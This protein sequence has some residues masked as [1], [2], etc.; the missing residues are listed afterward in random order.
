MYLESFSIGSRPEQQSIPNISH[1]TGREI[2]PKSDCHLPTEINE[3]TTAL[4]Q[5]VKL[6]VFST[7]LST[8]SCEF[9]LITANSTLAFVPEQYFVDDNRRRRLKMRRTLRP[10]VES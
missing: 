7:N 5:K 1:R 2:N 4:Y 9:V 6:K 3:A 8:F 10:S